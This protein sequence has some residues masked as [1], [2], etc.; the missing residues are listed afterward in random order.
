MF[1]NLAGLPHQAWLGSLDVKLEDLAEALSS[2][3]RECEDLLRLDR[4]I[5]SK[6]V[7]LH[8]GGVSD[9]CRALSAAGMALEHE[10]VWLPVPG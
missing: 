7:Q 4:E 10:S 2:Y 1:S 3:H 9:L 5:E 6:L 8:A